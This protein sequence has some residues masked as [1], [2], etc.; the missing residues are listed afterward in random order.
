MSL[1]VN[2][3]NDS[4][5][6]AERAEKDILGNKIDEYYSKLSLIAPQYSPES[7]YVF[8]QLVFHED[9]LYK[10]SVNC[11]PEEWDQYHWTEVN[12]ISDYIQ[13]L[14]HINLIPYG[15]GKRSQVSSQKVNFATR[16]SGGR[17][18]YA[19]MLQSGYGVYYFTYI[20]GRSLVTMTLSPDGGD[21]TWAVSSIS[22][23]QD[24]SS[25]IPSDASSSNQLVTTNTLDTRLANFGGFKEVQGT[26][27]DLHPNVPSGEEDSKLIY[28]VRDN[29][30]TG[31]DKYKEW[32]WDSGDPEANPPVS[33]Q[34]KLIGDT[35]MHLE[36][37]VQKVQID[38]TEIPATSG[39]VN[40]PLAVAD[41]YGTSGTDGALSKEDKEKIDSYKYMYLSEGESGY[42][43]YGN[44]PDLNLD[45]GFLTLGNYGYGQVPGYVAVGRAG[46][47]ECFFGNQG[48]DP[49]FGVYDNQSQRF[50]VRQ[51]VTTDSYI[52]SNLENGKADKVYDAT[53]GNLAALDEDGNLIDSGI[54][55]SQLNGNLKQGL[56]GFQ[57]TQIPANSDLNT[58]TTPGNYYI[59][60]A[61]DMAT[62][63][64]TP[65]AQMGLS[66]TSKTGNSQFTVYNMDGTDTGRVMQVM[67][68]IYSTNPAGDNAFG[69][70]YRM[71]AG[72]SSQT[73]GVWH[74]MLQT[75]GYAPYRYGSTTP[76]TATKMA[77][78]LKVKVGSTTTYQSITLGVTISAAASNLHLFALVTF[79]I[80]GNTPKI[81]AQVITSNFPD[82]GIVRFCA[83]NDGELKTT[84]SVIFPEQDDLTYLNVTYQVLDHSGFLYESKTFPSFNNVWLLYNPQLSNSIPIY[85]AF[86]D[87]HWNRYLDA[88][89]LSNRTNWK[90]TATS[91][92]IGLK[93]GVYGA[94]TGDFV[95]FKLFSGTI[96]T[97]TSIIANL[98]WIQGAN[99]YNNEDALNLSIRINFQTDLTAPSLTVINFENPTGM[100]NS[101]DR[102]P[103][104]AFHYKVENGTITVYLRMKTAGNYQQNILLKS[105]ASNMSSVVF[106]KAESIDE[107]TVPSGLTQISNIR[108]PLYKASTSAIG[109]TTQPVY[110]DAYGQVNACSVKE[111]AQ[112]YNT[113]GAEMDYTK[114]CH[115]IYDCNNGTT[116][117][118]ITV[119]PTKMIENVAYDIG[120]VLLN[121]SAAY[122]ISIRYTAAG[123]SYKVYGNRHSIALGAAT[124]E[125]YKASIKL[126]RIGTNVYV[127]GY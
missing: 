96:S 92:Y 61:A 63:S 120:G 26:G 51:L 25:V 70:W 62:I 122:Y 14:Q 58:Y 55:P 6:A 102:V 115:C 85:T 113:N 100:A 88:R 13:N 123:S 28:L 114:R 21:G 52:L 94:G 59:A 119:N 78:L 56:Q 101:G 27:S 36:G 87:L 125:T 103:Y 69:F 1:F 45:V 49:A 29:S 22:I 31:D 47:E 91:E 37:Y 99:T 68:T 112:Y 109:S 2:E 116:I 86:T 17:T 93:P 57:G 10:C 74:R 89:T 16:G 65:Y 19:P 72:G 127:I 18:Y 39:T 38:G 95:Y 46:Q 67:Y 20:D 9:T 8:D 4:P 23:P 3:I 107:G 77:E 121:S 97:W 71:S 7:T 111:V 41:D 108:R 79:S 30:A 40:I 32:I 90:I 105:Y 35:T 34:W 60:S 53:S 82:N 43:M 33:A 64:H 54:D 75:N 118:Y 44:S 48:S 11:G 24:Y 84:F 50:T 73:W 12:D 83:Y 98:L 81:D 5:L 42:K 76:S 124:T 110:V 66:D 126:V 80:R 117:K 15:S 104:S 106:Y